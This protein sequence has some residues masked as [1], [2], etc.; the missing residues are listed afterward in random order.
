MHLTGLQMMQIAKQAFGLSTS[1]LNYSMD[2]NLRLTRWTPV[3]GVW[4][5]PRK[6]SKKIVTSIFFTI[7]D[8]FRFF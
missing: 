4:S 3:D 5:T 7:V 6:K 2:G 8:T 1:E